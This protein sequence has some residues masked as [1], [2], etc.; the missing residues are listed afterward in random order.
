M[1]GRFELTLV[2]VAM[3]ALMV[4]AYAD[5]FDNSFHFD[6]AHVIQENAA[7]RD[8]SNIPT[9]FADAT[10]GSTLPTNRAYRP[11][12]TTTFAIDY[13]LGGGLDPVA[14][15]VTGLLIH[16]GVA[17][18]MALLIWRLM[19]TAVRHRANPFIAVLLAGWFA[20]HA[21]NAETVNYV[22]ARSDSLSTLFVLAALVTYVFAKGPWRHLAYLPLAAGVLVKSSAVMV[23]PLLLLYEVLFVE[24]IGIRGA[25]SRAHRAALR[26]ALL[27]TIPAAVVAAGF[28][29]LVLAMTP[30]SWDPGGG[31]VW[32]YLA[33]Q[34]FVILR[35]FWTFFVP[36]GLSADTDW[37]L[38]DSI[39][40]PR[41]LIGLAFIVAAVAASVLLSEQR[42]TRPVAFGIL[43]FFVALVPTS[44]VVP[45]AEV[46]NDHRMYLPFVGLTLAVGWA[47]ALVGFR[48][49]ES[50]G[51]SGGLQ[52]AVVLSIAVLLGAHALGT[53]QRSQVWDTEESLWLD[54]TV[55]SPDNGRGLMNYGLT[56]MAVGRYDVALDYF[57][58]AESTDY[59][60]HPYLAINTA[61]ALDGLGRRDAV[62]AYYRDAV[63]R[64]PGYPATHYYYARWLYQQGRAGEAASYLET[65]LALSPEYQPALLLQAEILGR[66]DRV[67][68][69]ERAAGAN[70]TS[71]NLIEL[72]LQYYVSGRYEDS[73]DA[74]E[75]AL[76][77][78]PQSA[79]AYNNICAAHNALGRYEDAVAACGSALELAPD[80]EVARS[81]LEWALQQLA[82]AGAGG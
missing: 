7:I 39:A 2:S 46:T 20:V 1:A 32:W 28:L 34:P 56:Q 15:H 75:R 52:T 45:L 58:R 57:E 6:D 68:E 47:L 82:G 67:A 66:S 22:S 27:R 70:P 8:L 33:T 14:F 36:V 38:L 50:I 61:L 31:S 44:S 59:G 29:V 53:W 12:L 48:Y 25:F 37:T 43:W 30:D 23:V 73:I 55:K 54:V 62:E 60:S 17:A 41:L 40:D 10:S 42:R 80:F 18:L 76:A 81:N 65:A 21:A 3:A 24:S 64:G 79:Y 9:F 69:A 63:A 78:D 77:V 49:E 71:D 19:D 13:W 4:L 72:S 11:L 26:R 35:Y 16:F 5:H 74:A 51:R